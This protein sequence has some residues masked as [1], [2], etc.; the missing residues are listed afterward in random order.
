MSGSHFDED[1]LL[2]DSKHRVACYMCGKP[3]YREQFRRKRGDEGRGLNGQNHFCSLC[4]AAK[5]AESEAQKWQSRK[6]R[7][8]K[9]AR[10]EQR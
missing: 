9:Q 3:L 8:A 6:R 5:W 2:R 7:Q 1:G 10:K 4:C